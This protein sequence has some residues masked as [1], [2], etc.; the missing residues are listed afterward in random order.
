MHKGSRYTLQISAAGKH[1]LVVMGQQPT[2]E[3]PLLALQL[4]KVKG[5]HIGA[6][7]GDVGF[8]DWSSGW[9]ELHLCPQWG[10]SMQKGSR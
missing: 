3:M 1:D 9:L 8:M 5:Q 4:L 6:A 10:C 7:M 2:A